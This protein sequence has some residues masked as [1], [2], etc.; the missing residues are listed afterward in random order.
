DA[1]LANAAGAL[2]VHRGL[3][4]G[5]EAAFAAALEDARHAVDG[6]AATTTLDNWLKLASTLT[7]T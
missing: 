7:G 2:A 1:V 3:P 6:G 4:G 5:L